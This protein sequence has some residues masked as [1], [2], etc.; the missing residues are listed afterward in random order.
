MFEAGCLLGDVEIG[1]QIDASA[2]SDG[3]DLVDLVFIVDGEDADAPFESIGDV[4]AHLVGIAEGAATHDVGGVEAQ[5]GG[6]AVDALDF[7]DG[8]TVESV[9]FLHDDA[10]QTRG[11]VGLQGILPIS[12][13]KSG[14][15]GSKV[16][17]EDLNVQGKL[18]STEVATFA[19]LSPSLI[20]DKDFGVATYGVVVHIVD[21]GVPHDDRW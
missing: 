2:G 5:S 17:L 18:R 4:L 21:V 15:H 14:F 12:L 16:L 8:G 11:V 3:R 9:A 10:E 20:R 1:A 6:N 13:G 19:E 7:T